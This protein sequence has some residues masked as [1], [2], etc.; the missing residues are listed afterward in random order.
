MEFFDTHA[1][2]DSPQ[3]ASDREAVIARA[4]AAGVT[5]I[6]TCGHDLVSSQECV[7]L[8]Q[9]HRGLYAA[10]GIHAH[11][12]SS[13]GDSCSDRGAS[14]NEQAFRSLAELASSAR[15]VAIGEIGLDYHYTFSPP[16]VQCAVLE[17]QLLLAQ[18]L[19]LPV[20][21]HNRES[22][23]DLRRLVGEA[24]ARA[25]GRLRGVLH[26]FLADQPMAEWAVATGLYLGVAGPVTFQKVTHLRSILT[27]VPHG[28]LLIETDCPY[29]APHPRRG[30]RNEPAFVTHV[31]ARLGELTALSLDEVVAVT[32]ANAIRLFGTA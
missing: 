25:G 4:V 26:C 19:D 1:H 8:A 12:A 24:S 29:L 28:R 22:D 3:F 11:Q 18:E 16:Q 7:Q 32:T 9:T 2:L 5:R 23:A 10:A 21:L 13:V 17:R 14:L 15:V 31:V 30:T 20:V 6:L 27:R